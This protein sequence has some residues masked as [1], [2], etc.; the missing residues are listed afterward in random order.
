MTGDELLTFTRRDWLRDTALPHL[1]SDDLIFLYLNEG[2]EQFC[3]KTFS[4][5][6]DQLS[7]DLSAGESSYTLDST[8]LFVFKAQ[9]LTQTTILRD[10]TWR[11]TAGH[12][13][14]VSMPSVFT[15]DEMARTLRVYPTPDQAYTLNL[16]IA[17]LP[18]TTIASGVDP[19]L[20]PQY[21]LDLIEWTTYRCLRNNDIDGQKKD[22]SETFEL[23]W[24]KRIV[25]A[26]R[27]VFRMRM[28]F[29]PTAQRS[30]TGKRSR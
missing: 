2:Q 19:E 13:S 8:V 29:D 4:L 20:D 9:L 12:G 16:G 14:A 25:D 28:G 15:F 11:K 17:T 22:V 26:K 7:I 5:Y 18:T 24:N 23:A 27:E 21:H 1:W 30:W 6:N 3:R 10:L